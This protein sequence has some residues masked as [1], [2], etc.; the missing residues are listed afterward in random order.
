MIK[1]LVALVNFFVNNFLT[2]IPLLSE[3]HAR[4]TSG[5]PYLRNPQNLPDLFIPVT[6]VV[7]ASK[8]SKLMSDSLFFEAYLQIS[9]LM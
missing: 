5:K 3:S 2:S 6:L 4:H 9:N 8:L 1:L 7:P